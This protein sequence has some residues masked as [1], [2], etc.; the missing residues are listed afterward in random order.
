MANQSPSIVRGDNG[1]SSTSRFSREYCT[2]CN[3][4]MLKVS[5]VCTHCKKGGVPMGKAEMHFNNKRRS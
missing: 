5:G 4:E 1:R 2:T 3:D